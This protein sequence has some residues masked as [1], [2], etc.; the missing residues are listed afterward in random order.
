MRGEREIRIRLTETKNILG[1][2][3]KAGYNLERLWGYKEA[4]EWV[5]EQRK[6]K[7]KG[8]KRPGGRGF[9]GA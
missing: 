8:C 7:F 5:L 3:W 9:V 1:S 4:L 2:H 6:G